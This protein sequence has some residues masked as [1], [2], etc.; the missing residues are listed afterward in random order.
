MSI[1]TIDECS[2]DADLLENV[3]ILLLL[4]TYIKLQDWIAL[5]TLCKHSQLQKLVTD[6]DN[7]NTLNNYINYKKDSTLSKKTE[8]NMSALFWK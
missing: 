8:K 5:N 2:R 3:N 1:Y 4:L 7:I 6:N